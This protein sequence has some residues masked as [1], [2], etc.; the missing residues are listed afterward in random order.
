MANGNSTL[1]CCAVC[2]HHAYLDI[3][4]LIQN[5]FAAFRLE[6]VGV[7]LATRANID[8]VCTDAAAAGRQLVLPVT[9]FTCLLTQHH[10]QESIPG[11]PSAWPFQQLHT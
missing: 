10:L 6:E 5:S 8:F 4:S 7:W 1:T 9:H 3:P 2:T 11:F